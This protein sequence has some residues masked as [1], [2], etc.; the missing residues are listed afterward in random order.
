L[1]HSTHVPDCDTVSGKVLYVQPLHVE[2][3]IAATCAGAVMVAAGE[4]PIRLAAGQLMLMVPDVKVA[5][6][7]AANGT[8]AAAGAMPMPM[9]AAAVARVIAAFFMM[10]F[11]PD[12]FHS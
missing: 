2:L 5:L 4:V 10:L 9:A 1:A 12:S 3:V 6:P 7:L 8:L 11:I